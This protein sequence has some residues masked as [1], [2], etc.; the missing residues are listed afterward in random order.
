MKKYIQTIYLAAASLLIGSMFF[1]KFATIVGANGAEATI[2]YSE[3]PSY[4]IM[5]IMLF[6]AQVAAASSAKVPVLQARVSVI[7]ALLACGFQLWLGVDFFM[8]RKVMSFSVTALFPLAAVFLDIMAA[9]KSMVDV[10]TLQT[11]R[12]IKTR[13]E[14]NK[15][16]KN[17]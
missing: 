8:N 3:K 6:I 7:A 15:F 12:S 9:H 10:F 17:N 16:K 4:L 13:S 14:R 11:A 1:L 5:L 2:N